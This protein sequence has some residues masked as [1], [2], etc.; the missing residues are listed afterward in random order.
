[1]SYEK[2]FWKYSIDAVMKG[3]SRNVV[4][5]VVREI[6]DNNDEPY[7]LI[8]WEIELLPNYIKHPLYGNIPLENIKFYDL[9]A[10]AKGNIFPKIIIELSDSNYTKLEEPV[11]FKKI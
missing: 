7:K 1:M 3:K 6:K 2:T 8:A 11:N 5:G 10:R 4:F 9:C